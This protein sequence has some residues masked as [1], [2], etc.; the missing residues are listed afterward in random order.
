MAAEIQKEF[1]LEAQLIGG[2]GGVFEVRLGDELVF[3]NRR[4]GG[5][6]DARPVIE[7]LRRALAKEPE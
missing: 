7:S 3:T 4:V 6:P 5:V 1:G 2:S